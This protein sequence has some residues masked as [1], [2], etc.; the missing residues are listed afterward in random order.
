MYETFL[1][2]DFHTASFIRFEME[3]FLTTRNIYVPTEFR[4]CELSHYLFDRALNIPVDVAKQV[5]DAA[6]RDLVTSVSTATSSVGIQA[7]ACI[8]E[9]GDL[10]QI[11]NY[12][13]VFT[14]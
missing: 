11:M 14:Y 5:V 13:I 3:G 10:Q 1:V 8:Q 9:G 4:E 7:Q 12:I 2:A 6:T